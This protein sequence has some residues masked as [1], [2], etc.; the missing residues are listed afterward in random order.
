M[1]YLPQVKFIIIQRERAIEYKD[2]QHMKNR[3]RLDKGDTLSISNYGKE[4][5]S[6]VVV[7]TYNQKYKKSEKIFDCYKFNST[8]TKA[9]SVT[10]SLTYNKPKTQTLAKQYTYTDLKI[11]AKRML[12]S[13]FIKDGW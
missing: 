5:Y 3:M 11:R 10:I 7:D 12:D 4:S 6:C 9:K 13:L 1:L 2:T 8:R